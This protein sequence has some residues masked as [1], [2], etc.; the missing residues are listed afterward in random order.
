MCL[1]L[2]GQVK[3]KLLHRAQ[4]PA[5]QLR[6]WSLSGRA[7][8]VVSALALRLSLQ[9]VSEGAHPQGLMLQTQ[10]Q[11]HAVWLEVSP[12]AM[13]ESTGLGQVGGYGPSEGM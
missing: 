2:S 11:A 12:T 8:Y 6:W 10:M 7:A 1:M 13:T 9:D 4:D 5:V 3:S